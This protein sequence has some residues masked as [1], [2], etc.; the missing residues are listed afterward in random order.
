MSEF[1]TPEAI[2][3]AVLNE[4]GAS[5]PDETVRNV[6]E[7][8]EHNEAGVA[9]DILCSQIFEYGIQL[10]GENSARLK[11]AACLMSIPLSQLDGMAD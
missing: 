2:I 5:F 4:V 3:M 10:S 7:L 6:G 11:E 1:M 8:V 9:L